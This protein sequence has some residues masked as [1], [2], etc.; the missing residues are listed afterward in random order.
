MPNVTVTSD[1]DSLLKSAD[2]AAIRTNAGL[3]A[4]DTV[5][6]GS[7]IPPSGTTAE[8]DAVSD[9]TVGSIMVN[10]DTKDII[11]FTSASAYEVVSPKNSTPTTTIN[12]TAGAEA[13]TSGTAFSSA[14]IEFDLSEVAVG[15]SAL[16]EVDCFM[17]I[18]DV[19]AAGSIPVTTLKA[20][21]DVTSDIGDL[22][23]GF[24]ALPLTFSNES[25]DLASG[26]FN[27]TASSNASQ[28]LGGFS[29]IKSTFPYPSAPA[30][31][32]VALSSS[33]GLTYT[34]RSVK[35]FITIARS[36]ITNFP[37]S[38]PL[39]LSF[40]VTGTAGFGFENSKLQVTKIS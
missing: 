14:T 29:G 28:P 13:S 36:E 35:T 30:Q 17:A 10:T 1:V 18:R 8:I 4:T 34:M 33:S 26:D 6:F 3:G 32:L 39:S 12:A 25:V 16:F 23:F 40:V 24:P 19:N 22:G 20:V 38:Y 21:V 5:S 27:N 2:K 15:E 7:F 11:R 31:P 37:V 9:A